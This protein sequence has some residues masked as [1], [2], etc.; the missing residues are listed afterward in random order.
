[1]GL[2]ESR[3]GL[4]NSWAILSQSAPLSGWRN[5]G[6][7]FAQQCSFNSYL[8]CRIFINAR[9]LGLFVVWSLSWANSSA[10]LSTSSTPARGAK[11]LPTGPD[12]AHGHHAVFGVINGHKVAFVQYI[13]AM[14]FPGDVPALDQ[15]VGSKYAGPPSAGADVR[16]CLDHLLLTRRVGMII[17]SAQFT[18]CQGAC[19]AMW[20]KELGEQSL[21]APLDAGSFVSVVRLRGSG[22]AYSREAGNAVS[23]SQ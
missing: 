19:R 3:Q 23:M 13:E 6:R 22:Q 21:P 10:Y 18:I 9:S 8:L 5:R 11:V 4:F 7:G 12:G 15:A 17:G 16:G 1:M 14:A 2:A 20:L